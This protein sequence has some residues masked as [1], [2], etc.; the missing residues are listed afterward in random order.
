VIRARDASGKIFLDGASDQSYL[1]LMEEEV[2][3]WTYM[4]FPHLKSLGRDVGWYRVGPLARVQNCD[5]IPSPL[6]E[7]ERREFIAW[8]RGEPVHAT[9]AYHWARMIE[10]LHSMEVIRDLLADPELLD[11]DLMTTG[12]RTGK[13]V[14]IIEA[15]RG[16][17]IHDY[18]V[19]DDDLVTMCNLIV[20]TTHN[21]QAMNEA[22]RS[23]ARQFLDGREL[24]EGL[25]NHIEIAIRAYDPCLSCA[26]HALGRMPLDVVL[27]GPDG[28]LVDHVL[29]SPEGELV[30]NLAAPVGLPA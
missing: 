9:L 10:V 25:L 18:R 28:T 5:F 19:G 27:Q 23:V 1:D 22:V 16:T 21:N 26:T 4:K 29:R 20:S 15:P 6:A 17:L 14:G 8:G 3:P 24:T 13:G 11:G 30:R 12:E 7:A 2:R